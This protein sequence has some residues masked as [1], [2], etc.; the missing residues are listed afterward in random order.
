MQKKRLIT[1]KKTNNKNFFVAALIEMKRQE[2]DTESVCMELIDLLKDDEELLEKVI[3]LV[4][5]KI[6]CYMRYI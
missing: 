6:C 5:R 1:A 3:L 4:R 2:S